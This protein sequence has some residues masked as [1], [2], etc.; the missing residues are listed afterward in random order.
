M[1]A[2]ESAGDV[3]GGDEPS[4]SLDLDLG[5]LDITNDEIDFALLKEQ[6]ERVENHKA[7]QDALAQVSSSGGHKNAKELAKDVDVTLREVEVTTRTNECLVFISH[8]PSRLERAPPV[9]LCFLL[10]SNPFDSRESERSWLPLQLEREKTKKTG[11]KAGTCHFPSHFF[12]LQL[13]NF[14][15]FFFGII[16]FGISTFILL[17]SSSSRVRSG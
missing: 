6:L 2:E 9:S 1:L 16:F 8:V 10:F 3:G 17:P 12:P 11:K 14:I 13:F 7:I 5:D 15:D 4:V